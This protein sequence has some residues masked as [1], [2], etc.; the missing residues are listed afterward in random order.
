MIFKSAFDEAGLKMLDSIRERFDILG[1]SFESITFG[2]T[3]YHDEDASILERAI[4]DEDKCPV[5][6]VRDSFFDST[7]SE[8]TSHAMVATGVED[9]YDED[10]GEIWIQLKNSY[11]DDPNTPGIISKHLKKIKRL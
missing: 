5:V 1:L 11:R 7:A 3:K 9:G 10:E 2:Y 8:L 4:Y 6:V